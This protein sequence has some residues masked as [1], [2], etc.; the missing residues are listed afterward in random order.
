MTNPAASREVLNPRNER[1]V[2]K[3]E[4]ELAHLTCPIVKITLREDFC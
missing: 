1:A 3:C 2:V 4:N